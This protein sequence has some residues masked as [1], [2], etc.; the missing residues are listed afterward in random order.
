MVGAQVQGWFSGWRYDRCRPC[1]T[2]PSWLS[3]CC[4]ASPLAPRRRASND[5]ITEGDPLP[6][7]LRLCGEPVDV[8]RSMEL[9]EPTYWIGGRLIRAAGGLREVPIETWTYNF[10]P[11]SFMRRLRFEDGAVVSIETLGYGYLQ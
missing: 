11:N 7:V 9:R 1:D 8:Q 6:R 10:G 3:C 5:L 4:R 2:A